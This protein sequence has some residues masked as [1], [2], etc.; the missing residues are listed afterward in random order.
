MTTEERIEYMR[1]H[2]SSL[3]MNWGEDTAVWEVSW[4]TSGKR[5]TGFSKDLRTAL[6]TSHRK[7]TDAFRVHLR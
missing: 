6:D 5:F 3:I 1:E 7:A 4:I 2:G